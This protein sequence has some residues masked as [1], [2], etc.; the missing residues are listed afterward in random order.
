M[1][2][3]DYDT[4]T[5][6]SA[7]NK[8]PGSKSNEKSAH[9]SQLL[10]LFQ[11]TNIKNGEKLPQ[12]TKT[13]EANRESISNMRDTKQ[14]SS[15]ASKKHDKVNTQIGEPSITGINGVSD[16]DHHGAISREKSKEN[17]T[18]K[19][20]DNAKTEAIDSQQSSI[21]HAHHSQVE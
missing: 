14:N 12:L 7:S 11:A 15:F 8:T 1:E 18:K 10:Q 2:G 20:E 5:V 13:V 21:T 4:K 16:T 6:D 9:K 17:E 3:T 19:K